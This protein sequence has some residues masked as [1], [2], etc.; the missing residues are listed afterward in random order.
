MLVD[1]GAKALPGIA[2]RG[3]QA[4]ALGMDDLF[5]AF[6]ALPDRSAGILDLA[7]ELGDA[8]PEQLGGGSALVPK[9]SDSERITVLMSVF[10]RDDLVGDRLGQRL[11]LDDHLVHLAAEMLRADLG[12][13]AH[14]VDLHAARLFQ[15]RAV[16]LGPL[17]RI[18]DLVEDAVQGIDE[19][20]GEPAHRGHYAV[21]LVA[22]RALHV[23]GLAHHV[24]DDRGRIGRGHLLMA[25]QC[26]IELLRGLFRRGDHGV[27][28]LVHDV[29]KGFVA[30]PRRPAALLQGDPAR[31][32]WHWPGRAHCW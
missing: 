3:G 20:A 22:D 18:A 24:G 4:L 1:L 26:G 12:G 28:L 6:G 5:Q 21:A 11:D 25:L 32:R 2:R 19:G 30:A 29:G 13:V 10:V 23:A 15:R 8:A 17:G 16:G 7:G 27:A 14:A 9:A 31:P